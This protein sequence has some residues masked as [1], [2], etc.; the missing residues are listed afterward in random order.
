MLVRQG[1]DALVRVK[2]GILRAKLCI[3]SRLVSEDYNPPNISV[4]S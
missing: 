2:T 4:F 3:A 1:L